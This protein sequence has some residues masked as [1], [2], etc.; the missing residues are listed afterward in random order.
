MTDKLQDVKQMG[1]NFK[2]T[3]SRYSLL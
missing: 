2:R 1:S 3:K